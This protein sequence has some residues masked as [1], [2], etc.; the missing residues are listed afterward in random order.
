MSGYTQIGAYTPATRRSSS[1]WE[2]ILAAIPHLWLA[3]SITISLLGWD[4]FRSLSPNALQSFANVMMAAILSTSL[5]VLLY[6]RSHDHPLWASA[7]SGYA[8]LMGATTLAS[9][10]LL[11]DNQSDTFRLGM[12]ALAYLAVAFGY[13]IRFR[14]ARLEALLM[15][16]VLLVEGPLLF[17]DNISHQTEAFFVLFLGMMAATI[18]VVTVLVRRWQLSLLLVVIANLLAVLL[19]A[20][21][22]TFMLV[23]PEPYTYDTRYTLSLLG[24]GTLLVL[25]LYVGTWLFWSAYERL[26]RKPA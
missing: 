14:R 13:F 19:Q 11:L 9:L 25:I 5:G 20:Y 26:Q 23:M 16:L 10:L 3:L 15:S 22:L 8:I 24:T 4:Y 17:L 6:A 18:A 21:I 7:W 2:P 1:A 12:I